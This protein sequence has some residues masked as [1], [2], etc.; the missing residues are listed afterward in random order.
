MISYSNLASSK[1]EEYRNNTIRLNFYFEN[2]SKNFDLLV[3]VI[4]FEEVE[5]VKIFFSFFFY[6]FLSNF[7]F[8]SIDESTRRFI[9]FKKIP[10]ISTV[11]I[12]HRVA[13]RVE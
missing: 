11:A 2:R 13:E 3:I 1:T 4:D 10:A 8:F 7:W 6:Q 5:G 12:W 9:A